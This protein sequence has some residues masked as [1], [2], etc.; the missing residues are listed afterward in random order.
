[1]AIDW[2]EMPRAFE[3]VRRSGGAKIFHQPEGPGTFGVIAAIG[4]EQICQFSMQ[5]DPETGGTE[6]LLHVTYTATPQSLGVTKQRAEAQQWVTNA[7]ALLQHA[8]RT[9]HHL[10]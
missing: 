3:I 1:M 6:V 2:E 7:N 10:L 5:E 8:H 9:F 4:G